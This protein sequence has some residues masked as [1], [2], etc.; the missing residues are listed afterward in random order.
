L[1]PHS[2]GSTPTL[3]DLL[4]IAAAVGGVVVLLLLL[5]QPNII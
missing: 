5:A 3:A 1:L 4:T 2:G